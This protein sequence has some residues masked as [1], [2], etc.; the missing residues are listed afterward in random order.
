MANLHVQQKRRNYLWLWILII[1]IIAAGLFYYFN[2]YRKGTTPLSGDT[3][4]KDS[5][6]LLRNLD[7]YSDAGKYYKWEV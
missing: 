6:L 7:I 5:T 4:I 3:G 1:L 2:Y